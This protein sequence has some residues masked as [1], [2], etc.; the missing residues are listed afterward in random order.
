MMP[1]RISVPASSANLGPG[2][3][4][5]GLALGLYIHLD[6]ECADQNVFFAHGSEES[7]E[8]HFIWNITTQVAERYGAALPP[9]KVQETNEIPLARGLGSS[10][11]AIVAGIELANQLG[12]LQLTD[13]Q[14]LAFGTEI[15]GHPDNIAPALFGGLTISTM[16][17][18]D[19]PS[20]RLND[21]E[22]DLIAY[23]PEVEL[24]TE[25]ARD[26]LPDTYERGYAARASAMSNLA[27][28]ALYTKDYALFGK[29]LENDLFHEPFRK[30]LIPNFDL[31][32]EKAKEAGAYGTALSGAGPTMLSFM[33]K[34]NGEKVKNEMVKQ[35]NGYQV[36]LLEIDTKGV[37]ISQNI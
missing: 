35:L 29:M 3:D 2:F 23:I 25:V 32:R 28:A 13:E 22:L 30:A 33:P 18:N 1:F 14:K 4:S 17:K 21:I 9:C 15:E 31:I 10:A 19:I 36:Q 16:L 12:N 26:C 6:V 5:M 34:G 8:N 7:E 37:S 11:S 24:K 20:V 27:V